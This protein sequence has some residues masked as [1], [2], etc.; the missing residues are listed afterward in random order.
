MRY[1]GAKP[2]AAWAGTPAAGIVDLDALEAPRVFFTGTAREA[3]T[4]Y[5]KN[6][7][8]AATLALAGAGFEA[9][10]VGAG[11]RPLRP[12]QRPRVFRRLAARELHHPH[13]EQALRRQRQDIR[14]DGAERTPRNT[15]TAAAPSSSEGAA[16]AGRLE[17]SG[18]AISIVTPARAQ[19][20]AKAR[21]GGASVTKAWMSATSQIRTGAL[22]SNFS[23]SQTRMVRRAFSTIA[24]ATATSRMS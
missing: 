2:P 8:V 20:S 16:G 1:R 9:T 6:A 4:A 12:R 13:R 15:G 7:N 18:R 11:G 17:S 10:A 22:R 23:R 19:A 24:R 14:D 3:A 21:G 5:P